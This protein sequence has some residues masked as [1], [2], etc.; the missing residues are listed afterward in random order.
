MQSTQAAPRSA[1]NHNFAP[2][3]G[4]IFLIYLLLVAVGMIGA[5]FKWASGGAE[6]ARQLFAFATNPLMG[7]VVGA[8][9]TALV[10]SSS[11][12]TSVIVGLVAGGLPVPTAIPMIMGANLGTTVTNTLVSMGHVGK[13]KEFR[14]AFSAATVHDFFNLMAVA[15]FL[16]LEIMTGYLSKASEYLANLLVGG[17]SVSIKGLDFIK[18]LTQPVLDVFKDLYAGLPGITG[19]V[20]LALTGLA[21][22]FLSI[23]FPGQTA[24]ATHG[25]TC[26]GNPAQGDW[27]WSNYRYFLWHPDD[28]RGT[29]FI[30]Y[31]QSDRTTGGEW[32]V[33]AEG[34]LSIH[35]G[36]QHRY[37]YHGPA[38]RNCSVRQ[39]CILCPADCPGAPAF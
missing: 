19:G 24:Q 32:P 16:P 25:W 37:H 21:F 27:S 35:S 1:A 38:G 14:R 17:S 8:M 34:N 2:W 10:Q 7:L 39:P 36:R 28:S 3:L 23:V 4:V 31:H 33:Q 11:T 29:V 15:I 22:I 20:M 9:A 5:G 12:V 26:Q 18:P 30:H 13:R 6:G